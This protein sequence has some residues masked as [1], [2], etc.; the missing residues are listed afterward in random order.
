MCLSAVSLSAMLCCLGAC[1]GKR[2]RLGEAPL[3]F[4]SGVPSPSEPESDSSDA[5]TSCTSSGIAANEVVW[6]GDSWFT[7]PG[8]QR[9]R[10]EE[11]ARAAGKLGEAESYESHAEAASDLAAII[12]Q[13]EAAKA[14]ALPRVL[15]MDGGTWD[16][17]LS[18]GS[19]ASVARVIVEFNDFLAQLTTEGSVQHVVY[20]LVPELPQIPGVAELR[21]G[22][23]EACSNSVV[24]CHFLDLQP[25]WDGHPEYTSMP[26]GI[27]ASAQGAT[28][29][30]DRIWSVMQ[31]ECVAQ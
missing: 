1:T 26:D 18:N 22:L 6:I 8:S 14:V 9:T 16:T 27:Q 4:D 19:A 31:R 11:L 3:G 10:V 20:M 21:P 17:I 12:Q 29:I 25:L 15:I 30:A 2:I 24:P 28:V 5:T 23:V 7:I 13:Y